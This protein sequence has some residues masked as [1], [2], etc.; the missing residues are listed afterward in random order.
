MHR[1]RRVWEAILE[2]GRGRKALPVGWEE[3]GGLSGEPEGVGR[4]GR[5]REAF[6]KGEG[7]VSRPSRR[8]GKGREALLEGERVWEALLENRDGVGGPIRVARGV[9]NL[10]KG[11]G[12][13]SSPSWRQGGVEKLSRRARKGQEALPEIR[14]R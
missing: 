12:G 14:E 4:A 13:D 6:L 3:L 10:L 8:A 1:D 9:G 7:G 5:G 11:M 2:A